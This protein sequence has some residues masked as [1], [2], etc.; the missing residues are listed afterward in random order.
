MRMVWVVNSGVPCASIVGTSVYAPSTVLCLRSGT[1]PMLSRLV[2][3][4]RGAD[5]AS[6]E[7]Q[8]HLRFKYG[9]TRVAIGSS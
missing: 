9:I 8:R 1:V 4:E 6:H 3:L 2:F 7:R 5:D